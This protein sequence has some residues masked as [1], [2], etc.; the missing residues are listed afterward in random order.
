MGEKR[1]NQKRVRTREWSVR[2]VLKV[3]SHKRPVL[4]DIG[5]KKNLKK[6][7]LLIQK[8]SPNLAKHTSL[9][10]YI[11][12]WEGTKNLTERL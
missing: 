2:N 11:G 1:D 10:F 4:S 9:N 3:G 5:L 6:Q 12:I 8:F 7:E